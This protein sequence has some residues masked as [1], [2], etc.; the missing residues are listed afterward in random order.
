MFAPRVPVACGVGV[1][2]C[3]RCR[4]TGCCAFWRLRRLTFL[5]AARAI[6]L[7]VLPALPGSHAARA[8]GRVRQP[9]DPSSRLEIQ[10]TPVRNALFASRC[11]LPATRYAGRKACAGVLVGRFDRL[12]V[13]THRWPPTTRLQTNT[14]TARPLPHRSRGIN[15]LKRSYGLRRSRLKGAAGVRAWSA[16][17]ILAYNLDTLAIRTR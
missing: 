6:G 14:K 5:P 13:S 1:Q 15:H 12:A 2:G 11:L 10:M 8:R 7:G 16:W 4:A 9:A 3:V 17:A